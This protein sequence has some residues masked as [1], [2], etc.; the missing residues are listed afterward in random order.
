MWKDHTPPPFKQ[1]PD[2]YA[3][4]VRHSILWRLSYEIT[5]PKF[6]HVPYLG[7]CGLFMRAGMNRA[8]DTY[9]PDLVVSVHPLMQH[10][11][12]RI[13]HQRVKTGRMAPCN[14]A[15]VVT[16]FTT[17]HNTWFHPSATRCFVPTEYCAMLARQNGMVDQQIIQHGLP[18]RP[19]FSRALPSRKALRKS[20][21]LDTHLPTVLL[22]G[23]GEGMGALE[24]TVDQL[25]LQLG[26]QA[27]VVV[28]CGRNKK[29][30]ERL[31]AKACPG[32]LSIL[33][34]GFVDNIHEWM[35]AS[36]VIITKAGPGTIAEALISGLPILLN[37]NVPCQEEGNIPYVIDNG[38]GTFETDPVKIAAILKKWLLGDAEDKEAFAKMGARSKELGRPAAVYQI[39]ND[40]AELADTP[41]VQFGPARM[42]VRNGYKGYNG[43]DKISDTNT[44]KTCV[45]VA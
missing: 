43:G 11:P 30:L 24:A 14:F 35:G 27:Q 25:D 42:S 2:S 34:S 13:L 40:L 19:T 16:D 5:Q 3:F 1:M 32:G 22:V 17:C 41:D 38:V 31:S 23:G 15:T 26:S 9:Q 39:V 28:I 6:F 21:G 44:A 8:F 36:D 7:F 33:A 20:L 29:L 18:I 4:L 10:V 45:K 37:G 12:I